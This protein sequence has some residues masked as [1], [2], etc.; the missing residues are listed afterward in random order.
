MRVSLDDFGTGYS[1]ISQ[2]HQL[3]FDRIKI[4]RG[5]ISDIDRSEDS[6][7]IV[8]SFAMLGKGLGPADHRRRDRN[9]RRSRTASRLR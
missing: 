3:P 1:S 9:Q 6:A 2:L 5:F 7:A 8:H 4:D